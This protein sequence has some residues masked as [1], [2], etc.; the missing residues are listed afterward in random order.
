[1]GEHEHM[2][3]DKIK[4]G[5]IVRGLEHYKYVNYN[6]CI[7]DGTSF[8]LNRIVPGEYVTAE[9]VMHFMDALPPR[10]YRL[11]CAQIGEP[12]STKIDENTG[13]SRDTYTT[14]KC[15]EGDWLDGVWQFCGNC[16]AGESKER[17][18]EIPHI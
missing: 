9:V 1:M 17:G 11:D 7:E 15:I 10:T 18:K 12:Y 5:T 6:G 16:F 2:K 8:D 3:T 13:K 4:K 14:F